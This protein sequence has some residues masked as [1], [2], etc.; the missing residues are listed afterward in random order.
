MVPLNTGNAGVSDS[1]KHWYLLVYRADGERKD[2][3]PIRLSAEHFDSS[4]GRMNSARAKIF[5]KVVAR[6]S[7]L[8]ILPGLS[9]PGEVAKSACTVQEDGHSCGCIA[10]DAYACAAF[11]RSNANAPYTASE[12]RESLRRLRKHLQPDGAPMASDKRT[13]GPPPQGNVQDE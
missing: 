7:K 4:P 3:E 12:A 1:G 6:A 10:G 13:K 8:G 2:G 11:M 5:N 9:F